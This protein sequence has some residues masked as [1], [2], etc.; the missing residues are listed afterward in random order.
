MK[1]RSSPLVRHQFLKTGFSDSRSARE[2]L[3]TDRG[4]SPAF[5]SS[6]PLRFLNPL[7]AFPEDGRV[8]RAP[9]V[10]G[11]QVRWKVT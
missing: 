10:A 3:T 8:E 6:F 7:R 2:R 11:A 1:G 4:Q 5:T 9:H